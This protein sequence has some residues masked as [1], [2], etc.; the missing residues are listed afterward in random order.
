[1]YVFLRLKIYSL[2]GFDCDGCRVFSCA[3]SYDGRVK[4][5]LQFT[6]YS[7]GHQ[8]PIICYLHSRIYIYT[9]AIIELTHMM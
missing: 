3:F 2:R 9:R 7:T 4:K 6:E 1:M 5:R 8:G